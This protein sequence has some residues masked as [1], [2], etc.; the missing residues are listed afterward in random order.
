VGDNKLDVQNPL[1][2]ST[3]VVRSEQFDMTN[4]CLNIGC[5]ASV[6]E[7]C[8]GLMISQNSQLDGLNGILHCTLLSHERLTFPDP[9]ESEI[10]KVLGVL[11][12]D[13]N[14]YKVCIFSNVKCYSHVLGS[15]CVYEGK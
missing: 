11:E 2:S 9:N 1:W 6:S 4:S 10:L 5:W 8:N 3:T 15:K 12:S 7:E 13:A 14:T